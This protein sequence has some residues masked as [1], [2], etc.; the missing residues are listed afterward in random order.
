MRWKKAE[1]ARI[2]TRQ[3]DENFYSLHS[4]HQWSWEKIALYREA[5]NAAMRKY[6]R[7]FPHDVCLEHIAEEIITGQTQLWLILKNRTEFS[8]F[9]ITKIERTHNGKKR[10]VILDLAGQGGV[11]LVSLIDQLEQW[12]HSI[13]A[14]EILT[15][16]RSGWAKMLVHQ[17]YAINLIHYRKVLKHEQTDK[18]SSSNNDTNERSPLMGS[19]YFKTGKC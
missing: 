19:G 6:A 18:S 4:T 2:V 11:K 8:A 13:D 16:G 17:G 12:A 3:S 10:V 9:G 7:R 5:I 1:K 14:D 15:L